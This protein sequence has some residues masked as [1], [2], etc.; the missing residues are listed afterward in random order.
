VALVVDEDVVRLQV[1]VDDALGVRVLER[2]GDPHQDQPGPVRLEAHPLGRLDELEEAPALD[3]PGA[4]EEEPVA[5]SDL[6]E[7][8]DARVVE[9]VGGPGSLLD[10]PVRDALVG[11]A[12]AQD[13]HVDLGP[14]ILV[15]RLVDHAEA[16][17]PDLPQDA[18][19]VDVH[20]AR[21]QLEL[22][23]VLFR[24]H[25]L[26]AGERRLVG[27]APPGVEQRHLRVAHLRD[28]L[29]QHAAVG[30]P[31]IGLAGL[32]QPDPLEG[33]AQ[34]RVVIL[35]EIAHAQQDIVVRLFRP[36]G[37]LK[38]LPVV[39]V[40][41]VALPTRFHPS[42]SQISRDH[43]PHGLSGFGRW[44]GPGRVGGRGG[45]DRSIG[46]PTRFPHS[47]QEPS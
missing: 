13:A 26:A 11:E 32:E 18:I 10:P 19:P 12:R 20:R 47:V 37:E 1:A 31:W 22:P 39:V 40:A 25:F 21:G 7:A 5:G 38:H 27:L 34:D 6:V 16:A 29:R 3:R 30:G 2:V 45:Y 36:R 35:L 24:L 46:A 23:I 33:G 9:S 8:E 44:E 17:A 41:R 15:A 42:A 28:E 4:H 14:E 43:P